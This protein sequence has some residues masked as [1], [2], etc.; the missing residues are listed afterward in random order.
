L[1]R[2]VKDDMEKG[3]L[4]SDRLVTEVIRNA[5]IRF[6]PAKSWLLDG[7]PRT[8]EQAR[9]LDRVLE[10]SAR[11][12]TLVANLEV[13]ESVILE[14]IQNRWI[15]EPSGR[16]YNSQYNPPKRLGYDDISGDPLTRRPDDDVAVF[17]KRLRI[18]REV[19][20]E[21]LEHYC[22]RGILMNFRGHTSDVIYFQLA[23]ELSVRFG[24]SQ[25]AEDVNDTGR[26]VSVSALAS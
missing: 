24:L 18:H 17:E 25:L 12:L 1:G 11:P 10:S 5:L 19:T 6:P 23:E 2:R 26:D 3:G 7:F 8:A 13:P 16:V 15:H 9:T 4:V 14:R 22:Q 21:L 20:V